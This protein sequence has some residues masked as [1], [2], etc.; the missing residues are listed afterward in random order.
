[1]DIVCFFIIIFVLSL[2]IITY[3]RYNININLYGKKY[4]K[5]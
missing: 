2:D 1:M 4:H 3:I 5:I